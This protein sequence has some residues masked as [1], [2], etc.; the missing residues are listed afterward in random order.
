MKTPSS[1]LAFAYIFSSHALIKPLLRKAAASICTLRMGS[2]N[3]KRVAFAHSLVLL[4]FVYSNIALVKVLYILSYKFIFKPKYKKTVNLHTTIR[5]VLSQEAG[6]VPE[7]L[8]EGIG[9]WL[10]MLLHFM[11]VSLMEIDQ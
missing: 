6:E 1:A 11:I 4:Q 9:G 10:L 3:F 7:P 2:A 8:M 5:R